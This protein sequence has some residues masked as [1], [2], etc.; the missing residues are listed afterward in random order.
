VKE[1]KMSKQG[2]MHWI[3][4]D[5]LYDVI[6]VGRFVFR[7]IDFLGREYIDFTKTCKTLGLHLGSQVRSVKR[8]YWDTGDYR[9]V[10]GQRLLSVRVVM[11]WMYLLP[12]KKVDDKYREALSELKKEIKDF[13]HRPDNARKIREFFRE[14]G[15]PFPEP[16]L[17]VVEEK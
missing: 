9:V 2:E 11:M 10:H 17:R 16:T 12:I 13:L 4:G 7:K 14:N 15:F 8:E 6:L 5:T 3:D 1:R